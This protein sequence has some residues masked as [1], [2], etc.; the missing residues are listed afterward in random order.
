MRQQRK[1]LN[2]VAFFLCDLLAK[3]SSVIILLPIAWFN[4]VQTECRELSQKYCKMIYA[5]GGNIK[6]QELLQIQ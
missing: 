6:W 1:F 3:I 2:A 4:C 5:I